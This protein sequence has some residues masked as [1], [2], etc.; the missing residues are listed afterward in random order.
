[1]AIFHSYEMTRGYIPGRKLEHCLIPLCPVICCVNLTWGCPKMR[2]A[3]TWMTW[4][5]ENPIKVDWGYPYFRK[6]PIVYLQ[7]ASKT[8][9]SS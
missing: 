4:K 8:S 1:M 5:M 6:P 9:E 2:V 3:Q 7:D